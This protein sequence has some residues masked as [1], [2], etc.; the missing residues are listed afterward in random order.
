M[1]GEGG[2]E[3]APSSIGI[4]AAGVDVE[5]MLVPYPQPPELFVHSII[6]DVISNET[7]TRYLTFPLTLT[8]ERSKQKIPVDERDRIFTTYSCGN[9]VRATAR[10]GELHLRLSSQVAEFQSGFAIR[11]LSQAELER[12]VEE[13]PAHNPW[14][15]RIYGE[16]RI[17]GAH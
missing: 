13:Y 6:I 8:V 12:L 1:T 10:A 7:R 11:S 14:V 3:G 4:S 16:D 17:F 15:D 2:A 9:A 5:T